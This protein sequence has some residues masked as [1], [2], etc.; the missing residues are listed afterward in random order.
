MVEDEIA[1]TQR[2]RA[3][4]PGAKLVLFGHSLARSWRRTTSNVAAICWAG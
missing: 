4:H 3:A 2:L 1:Y